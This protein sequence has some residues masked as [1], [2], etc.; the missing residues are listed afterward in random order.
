[1]KEIDRLELIGM[2]QKKGLLVD[3]LEITYKNIKGK[4]TK[5][6]IKLY[7]SLTDN[8]RDNI[9]KSLNLKLDNFVKTD[10][11]ICLYTKDG[12]DFLSVDADNLM[13]SNVAECLCIP[14]LD[15]VTIVENICSEVQKIVMRKED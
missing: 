4:F 6:Q 11:I 14:I 12:K 8:L 7:V 5:S 9:Y 1:M 2:I 15:A 13:I 10:F 3:S